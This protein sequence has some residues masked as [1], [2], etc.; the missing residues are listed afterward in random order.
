MDYKMRGVKVAISKTMTVKEAIKKCNDTVHAEGVKFLKERLCD[1]THYAFSELVKLRKD[2]AYYKIT[3]IPNMER[4]G[5]EQV[6]KK[7]RA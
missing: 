6:N 1:K 7:R 3:L 4:L 5:K 2:C